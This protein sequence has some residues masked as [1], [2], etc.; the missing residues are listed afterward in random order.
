MKKLIIF[1]G[2][3]CMMFHTYS[4]PLCS[5]LGQTTTYGSNSNEIAYDIVTDN[6]SNHY[7]A[8]G[9]A[10]T[11]LVFGNDTLIN[12]GQMDIWV[13]KLDSN[14][15][16]I[17]AINA[18]GPNV[19]EANGIALDKNGNTYI[20]GYFRDSATF[21]SIKLLG[22]GNKDFFIAKL[23]HNGNFLWAKQAGSIDSDE[24]RKIAVDEDG[25]S[26]VTGTFKLTIDFHDTTLTSKGN[27]DF[28]VVKYDSNGN[29]VWIQHVGN[30]YLDE[31]NNIVTDNQGNFYITGR[32]SLNVTF[33]NIPLNQT[34]SSAFVAKL[35]SGGNFVWVSA[36]TGTSSSFGQG[37]TIDKENNCYV[38]G[39]FNGT[40]VFGSTTLHTT[41]PYSDL[42]IA[43][44]DASGNFIW[45]QQAGGKKAD[46][47]YD[48]TT[49]SYGNCFVTGS[50]I[51]SVY[52][53]SILLIGGNSDP[54]IFI[55]KIDSS[56]KFIWAHRAG[57][58]NIDA[59]RAISTDKYGNCYATGSY[60]NVG[61][62]GD[63]TIVTKGSYDIFIMK[64]IDEHVRLEALSDTFIHCGEQIQLQP[65]ATYQVLTQWSP[66]T[67]V[68]DPNILNPNFNPNQTTT[69]TLSAT[70][71][72]NT[73]VKS[74]ITIEVEYDNITQDVS[75]CKGDSF[76]IGNHAYFANGSYIDTIHHPAGCDSIILTNLTFINKNSIDKNVT[77][78]GNT[79]TSADSGNVSYQW[80][81]CD[82]N[83]VEI[84]FQSF[85]SFSPPSTGNYAVIITSNDCPAVSDTS[86]CIHFE[87]NAVKNIHSAE[88]NIFPNPV[89]TLLQ[90]QSKH[91]LKTITIRS[92]NGS[93]LLIQTANAHTSSMDISTLGNGLYLIEIE[94]IKGEI[95]IN[96][97]S[98]L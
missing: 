26:Y 92:I 15:N 45:A 49:D 19:D 85:R 82:K 2:L 96:K 51:D 94:N 90:I 95:T 46:L 44:L 67:G 63:S 62:F 55:A 93:I 75:I 61:T 16:F 40:P 52:F 58:N 35:D 80:I 66:A 81:D 68:S 42:F 3:L 36:N 30:S 77:Q 33:G 86:D 72:C 79:I 76:T 48:I 27:D 8:G 14:R 54:D 34:G 24:G 43:K 18:G 98:K 32:T 12:K 21:G 39:Q 84:P 74:S 60:A 71:I 69:Y 56:G 64:V 89:N 91:Q 41:T 20:T 53:D 50:V 11:M 47:A 97:V 9:F 6:N 13:A 5:K 28:F 10:S 37:I 4:Q 38:S 23:D 73:T 87:Y 78:H 65:K 83:N 70:D 88:I 31:C 57:G 29:F 17:W 7:L 22:N 59:A 1:F 25:N